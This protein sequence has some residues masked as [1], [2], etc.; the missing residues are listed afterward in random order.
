M[1][2]KSWQHKNLDF[3]FQIFPVLINGNLDAQQLFTQNFTRNRQS[4]SRGRAKPH[5]NTWHCFDTSP[6]L[7]KRRA[8][9]IQSGGKGE[10]PKA[11]H[12]TE[13]DGSKM[14][15]YSSRGWPVKKSAKYKLK[16]D[17]IPT[18]ARGGCFFFVIWVLWDGFVGYHS[19]EFLNRCSDALCI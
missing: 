5:R 12:E 18:V 9:K 17:F 6:T 7:I 11:V 13:S 1:T 4:L 2:T 19:L 16:N 15:R 14:P 3:T 10:L 8:S